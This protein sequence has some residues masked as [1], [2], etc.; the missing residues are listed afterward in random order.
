MDRIQKMSLFFRILFQFLSVLLPILLI[1]AWVKAPS[2][3][4]S[5]HHEAVVDMIYR[6][7]TFTEIG[8]NARIL[9]LFISF[10]PL[11]VQLSILYFLIKLFSLFEA[12]EVF[13]LKNVHYIRNIGYAL[14]VGQ[15]L[16]PI[17]EILISAT[18]TW[19][20]SVGHRIAEVSMGTDNIKLMITAALV[21]L[22]SWIMAEA[23]RLRDEQRLT[24]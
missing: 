10:I 16:N 18:L 11:G 19:H 9:G 13:T 17:Y 24:I 20:N 4:F 1:I 3:L 21:I 14:L 12:G 8:F 23:C 5:I 2:P 7:Q 22:V 15:L 6:G